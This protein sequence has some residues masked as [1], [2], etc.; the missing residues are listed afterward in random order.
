[1]RGKRSACSSVSVFAMPH[2]R[3]WA[4]SIEQQTIEAI[5][6]RQTSFGWMQPVR[7][8]RPGPTADRRGNSELSGFPSSHNILEVSY[9]LK[10]PVAEGKSFRVGGCLREQVTCPIRGELIQNVCVVRSG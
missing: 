3:S 7:D 4:V 10:N 2:H 6:E 5:D 8:S 1:M 9:V